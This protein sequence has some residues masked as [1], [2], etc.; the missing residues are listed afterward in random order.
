MTR[1]RIGGLNG[2]GPFTYSNGFFFR[3]FWPIDIFIVEKCDWYKSSS[4][5]Q[6]EIKKIFLNFVCFEEL[7]RFK[8]SCEH[9]IFGSLLFTFS[10]IFVRI[11]I[12]SINILNQ[13]YLSRYKKHEFGAPKTRKTVKKTRS[14]LI[15]KFTINKIRI[16]FESCFFRKFFTFFKVTKRLV[17]IHIEVPLMTNLNYSPMMPN[18]QKISFQAIAHFFGF[19][20]QCS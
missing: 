2:Y 8:V 12:F 14:G 10:L 5:V 17:T 6:F 9:E 7:S 11:N 15:G 1:G 20:S 13:N 18:K 19:D 3:Q 4:S 16:L